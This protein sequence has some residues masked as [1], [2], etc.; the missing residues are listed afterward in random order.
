MRLYV[1]EIADD[2]RTGQ[3]ADAGDR[4]VDGVVV[5]VDKVS[6]IEAGAG[7]ATFEYAEAESTETVLIY[8]QSHFF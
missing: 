6:R 4:R 8:H 2:R 1:F 3:F 5:M 7:C